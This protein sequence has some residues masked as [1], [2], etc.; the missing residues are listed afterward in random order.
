[1]NPFF[2]IIIPTYNRAHILSKPLES[3]KQQTFTDWE[4]IIVDDGSKDNTKELVSKWSS[5]DKRF[6][7]IYQDNA[8][9][10]V[11]R[12]NGIKNSK[13]QYI[14]FLDSDDEYLPNHLSVLF[15]NIRANSEPIALFF[16]QAIILQQNEEFKPDIVPMMSGNSFEYLMQNPIIP[17]RVCVN[18]QILNKI[19]FRE[20]VV[21]V[22]DQILWANIA[23]YYP[24]FQIKEYT[25]VYYIYE[26]NS[27]NIEKNCFNPRLQGLRLFFQQKD[28]KKALSKKLKNKLIS[29]CYFGI[30]RFYLF[31]RLYFRYVFNLIKSIYYSPLHPQTK[32]KIH[33]IFF[34][35]KHRIK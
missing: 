24:V 14:C 26:E 22:E 19:N 18:R 28:V 13:G 29:D 5:E 2:S 27:V 25:V 33:M 8:E 20:D 21:I 15:E 10:S 3:I 1:M 12:N 11:A 7:Y 32:A 9:R 34:P 30:S 17:A 31:K 6:R 16:T 4:C 23:L 35:N